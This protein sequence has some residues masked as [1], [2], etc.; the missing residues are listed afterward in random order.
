MEKNNF[1]VNFYEVLGVELNSPLKEIKKQYSKLVVKYHPDKNKDPFESSLFELIQRAYDTLGNEEKRTEYDFFIKNMEL[2]KNNDHI[3]LKTNYEKFKDLTDSQPK[4][5]DS[6]QIEFNK[7]FTDYDIKHGID[8]TILGEKIDEKMIGNKIDD[9]MLQREQE[10]IEFTQNAIFKNGQNFDISK[11]NA[12]FDLYKNTSDKQ[13]IKKSDIQPFNF[14]SGSNFSGLDVYEKTF[15]EDEIEGTN[16][17]SHVN[18]IGKVNRIDK[19]KIKNIGSV[20][21]TLNHNFKEVNY[22]EELKKK[23]QERD[24]ETKQI[25]TMKYNEYN[26]EDK[27]F[28]FSQEIGITENM[29]EWQNEDILTACKKLI[30]LEKKK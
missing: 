12:A 3:S 7:I 5:K 4:S 1:T 11:F 17:Y 10:E 8:R 16:T 29:L 24:M 25:E 9:L 13:I 21:Y 18:N 26:T 28:Q 15:Q 2:S 19:D 6:S 20:D 30:E 14:N 27:S 22:E 23:M